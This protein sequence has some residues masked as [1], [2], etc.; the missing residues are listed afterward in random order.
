MNTHLTRSIRGRKASAHVLCAAV[1]SCLMLSGCGGGGDSPLPTPGPGGGSGSSAS[2]LS[3]D[4]YPRTLGTL[5]EVC[6]LTQQNVAITPNL[7]VTTTAG[8]LAGHGRDGLSA[9]TLYTRIVAGAADENTATALAKSVAV[10]TADGSISETSAPVTSP[11]TLSVDFEVFTAPTTNLTLN[12]NA[13]N[14]SVDNYN[15]AL[16]LT[17]LA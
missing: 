10:S 6:L 12:S 1:A 14:M 17:P 7:S 2:T 9:F 4:G 11:E 13:G 5:T 16:Q 3:C 15:A 8:N